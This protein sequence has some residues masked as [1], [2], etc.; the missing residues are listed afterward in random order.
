[1]SVRCKRVKSRC[2]RVKRCSSWVS[3]EVSAEW[4]DAMAPAADMVEADEDGD[5]N[6]GEA[7]WGE[8]AR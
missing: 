2:R 1:M 8:R 4:M 5:E 3:A 7:R 6:G